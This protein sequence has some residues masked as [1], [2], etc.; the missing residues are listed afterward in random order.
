VRRNDCFVR[1]LVVGEQRL[2]YAR[3]HHCSIDH[4]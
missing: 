4:I 3:S 2:D 1:V